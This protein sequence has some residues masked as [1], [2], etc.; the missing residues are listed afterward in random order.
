VTIGFFIGRGDTATALS[1]ALDN[2]P[3]GLD[4]DEAK[5]PI[6]FNFWWKSLLDFLS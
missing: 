4:N 5:V 2:P 3:Y 6:I 1:I